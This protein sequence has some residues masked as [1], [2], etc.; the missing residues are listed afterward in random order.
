MT[1]AS[2]SLIGQQPLITALAK[3]ASGEVA[4][5]H[6][7]LFSGS[8]AVTLAAVAGWFRTYL[9]CAVPKGTNPCGTCAGCRS[10]L[11]DDGVWTYTLARQP[12]ETSHSV[13]QIRSIRQF[14]GLRPVTRGRR[15]V[16]LDSADTLRGPAANALLKNLEEPGEALVFILTAQSAGAVLPTIRS[17]AM[18]VRLQPVPNALLIK[19]LVA[20]GYTHSAAEFATQLFPG[21]AGR[22]VALLENRE[23]YDLFH[24]LHRTL[25][26][27]STLPTAQR[28]AVAT[29]ALQGSTETAA[30]RQRVQDALMLIA[31]DTATNPGTLRA[32]L[33][34]CLALRTNAQPKLIFDAFAL[35]TS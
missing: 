26:H 35:A 8:D 1:D 14:V 9:V 21:Q 25:A 28:L 10:S 32:L 3:A 2:P 19:A 30:Q 11:H 29:A 22:S 5:G 20:A 7:Y 24:G 27:W 6:A 12:D 18:Q 33:D 17:R 31:R 16:L 23:A 13:E 34:A 4:Y 15:V